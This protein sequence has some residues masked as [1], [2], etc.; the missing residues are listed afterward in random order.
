M[1]FLFAFI[2]FDFLLCVITQTNRLK[3]LVYVIFSQIS[4]RD[5]GSL[6]GSFTLVYIVL[7]IIIYARIMSVYTGTLLCKTSACTQVITSRTAEPVN[8]YVRIFK[9]FVF[10]L[11]FNQTLLFRP[12]RPG[13]RIVPSRRL[14]ERAPISLHE[15][16]CASTSTLFFRVPQHY[17][18][19]PIGTYYCGVELDQRVGKYRTWYA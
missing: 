12:N 5:D 4:L 7:I 14:I 19:V 3:L 17:Y 6:R 2:M 16:V 13:P 18:D 11:I 9:E 1:Y 8:S 10:V 15:Y